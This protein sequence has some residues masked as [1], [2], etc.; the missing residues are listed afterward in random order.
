MKTEDTCDY[1]FSAI[2]V[3]DDQLDGTVAA[4]K[5]MKGW[6][7]YE[8]DKNWKEFEIQVKPDVWGSEKLVFI[9]HKK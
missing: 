2:M 4:G 9:T 3:V 5:K 7:G 6:I 1:S 8:V